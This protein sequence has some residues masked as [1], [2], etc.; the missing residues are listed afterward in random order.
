VRP[1]NREK[2]GDETS[3]LPNRV[4]GLGA[5]EGGTAA[6]PLVEGDRPLACAVSPVRCQRSGA[7]CG[8]HSRR[9][10]EW[11]GGRGGR[12]GHESLASRSLDALLLH[13]ST[14]AR[15]RGVDVRA[16]FTME[17]RQ[18][19]RRR[20]RTEPS[21]DASWGDRVD[22]G[23]VLTGGLGSTRASLRIEGRGGAPRAGTFFVKYRITDRL[24][25]G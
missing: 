25:R 12:E 4:Q 13:H 21:S 24:V 8:N 9:E 19:R 22:R 16:F 23:V 14:T 7:R 17:K 20:Q 5:V 1:K 15:R 6:A 2:R 3:R 11:E 10:P 18:T